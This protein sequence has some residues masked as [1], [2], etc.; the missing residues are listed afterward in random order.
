MEALDAYQ[1][2]EAPAEA[3]HKVK[4]SKHFGYVFPIS[5]PDEAKAHLDALRKKHHDAR[6][7]AYAYRLGATGEEWRASDDGEPAN[8]AGPPILGALKSREITQCLAVV[9]RYFGGTKLGV[10]G[11]IDA[12]RTAALMAIDEAHVIHCYIEREVA[13]ACPYELLGTVLSTAE[14]H[15][16]SVKNQTFTDRCVVHLSIR[17]SLAA[18]LTSALDNVYGC[19]RIGED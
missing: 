19:T 12:Y 5:H 9:V 10:G 7:H 11:L 2:L 16:A 8:S 15:G 3:M 4:G 1:S 6:H 18:S 17:A 13:V 14:K